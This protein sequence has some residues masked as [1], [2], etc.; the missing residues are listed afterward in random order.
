ME[1]LQSTEGTY[2]KS[3]PTPIYQWMTNVPYS[4]ILVFMLATV[5]ATLES[6]WMLQAVSQ[7]LGGAAAVYFILA[8]A[9]H[10]VIPQLQEWKHL[11]PD[12]IHTSV[13]SW[14]VVTIFICIFLHNGVLHSSQD[15]L[16]HSCIAFL[17]ASLFHIKT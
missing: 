10:F 6:N 3:I 1:S 12:T 15:F 4:F 13:S 2:I 7:W 9:N 5:R 8:Y 11:D 16:I 14:I 17:F